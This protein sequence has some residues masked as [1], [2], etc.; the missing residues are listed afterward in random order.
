MWWDG[1]SGRFSDRSRRGTSWSRGR[2]SPESTGWRRHRSLRTWPA[3]A[4]RPLRRSPSGGPKPRWRLDRDFGLPERGAGFLASVADR[5]RV[6]LVDLG[7]VLVLAI[8]VAGIEAAVRAAAGIKATEDGDALSTVIGF[9]VLA[10]IVAYDPLTTRLFGATPGKWALDLRVVTQS[11]LEPAK[12]V[13]L[14]LRSLTMLVLWSC[15]LLPGI[16]DIAAAAHDPYRRAWHDNVTKTLVVRGQRRHGRRSAATRTAEPWRSLAAQAAATRDRFDRFASTVEPGPIAQGL[17]D[18]RRLIGD[19][20]ADCESLTARAEELAAV[21]AAVD[22]TGIRVRA[23][24]ARADALAHPEDRDLQSLAAALAAE[25]ASS[26]RVHALIASLDR[27]LHR[28]VAQLNDVVNQAIA[29]AF[30]PTR[31]ADIRSLVDQLEALREAFADT[32]AQV[33]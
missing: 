10:I 4:C 27:N 1:T 8:V 29:V 11:G 6:R 9:I 13:L 31:D 18:I 2:A 15:C 5:A 23:A 20:V 24:A 12:S 28:L 7:I 33:D 26:E 3:R 32:A 21:A 17:A 19:C 16:L 25:L 22:T 30:G 14:G